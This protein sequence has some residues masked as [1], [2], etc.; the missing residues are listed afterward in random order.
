M[1]R[2]YFDIE[3]DGLLPTVTKVH[4]L[5]VRVDGKAHRWTGSHIPEGLAFLDTCEAI[6]AHNGIGYDLMVLWTL[7][8]WKPKAEVV[9]TFVVSMV[10]QADILGGHSLE[11]W[12]ERLKCKKTDYQAAYIAWRTAEDEAYK[13]TP[14]EEWLSCNPVMVDYCAQDVAVLEKLDHHLTKQMDGADWTQALKVEHQF[15][16]DFAVQAWRGVAID[17]PHA[18][19]LLENITQEMSSIQ[20][21]VEPLLPERQGTKGQLQEATPPKQCFKKDGSLTK[22]TEAWFDEVV[23]AP[24]VGEPC[25]QS[26]W[27]G[28]KYGQWHRLPTPTDSDGDRMPLRTAFPMTLA[29]QGDLKS[30]LMSVGWVPTMW[31][32][33]KAKDHNGKMR[34]V[35]GDDGQLIPTQPKFHDKGVLCKNLES[36]TSDF[37]HVNQVVRWVILRHRHGFVQGILGAL[38]PDGT[39]GA[40]GMSCGT[41]TARVTH[42]VVANPPK[43]EPEVVLGKEIRQMFR[44]RKGRRFVGVDASGLELRCLAHYVGSPEIVKMVVEGTKEAGTEI[45]TFLWQACREWV[46]NRAAQKNV[47]YGWLYGASDRKLGQT[48]GHPDGIAEK[49]GK[50]IRTA[51]VKA[52]PGLEDFMEKVAQAAKTGYVVAIDGRIIKIRSKHAAL[53]TLLQSC[54]SILVKWATCYMNAKIREQRLDAYMV[55]HMHDEVQLDAHPQHAEQAGR[56][57]VEGL[58]WAAQ[59][60]QLRCPLDG[61]VKVGLNWA[62]TH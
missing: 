16:K 61:E 36:I 33:K 45:H 1:T 31:S 40:T 17:K 55:I 52:I 11:A 49:V 47:N 23:Y 38:R 3:A 54:G 37:E 34:L 24:W 18:V 62:T 56:L 21:T 14:G 12:G 28:L 27:Q 48:A 57:F 2:A 6:V 44:A 58:K 35:R 53:N 25:G 59:R 60:F 5:C 20:R 15:A 43:A 26:V 10:T 42:Q 8:R 4:V 50:K 9:D 22:H 7:Y 39:V 29:D 32:Y 13:Y 51:L 46:K 30:W 19:R 41:P